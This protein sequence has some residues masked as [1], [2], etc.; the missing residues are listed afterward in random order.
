MDFEA[1][2][3]RPGDHKCS[4]ISICID[5][6]DLD[7]EFWPETYSMISQRMVKMPPR[8]EQTDQR[9]DLWQRWLI[10]H[11]VLSKVSFLLACPHVQMGWSENKIYMNIPN[12]LLYMSCY[13]HGEMTTIKFWGDPIYIILYLYFYQ[14]PTGSTHLCI[15]ILCRNLF[16]LICL[17]PGYWAVVARCESAHW[18]VLRRLTLKI[19]FFSCTWSISVYHHNE[20]LIWRIS[21]S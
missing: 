8:L 19:M 13:F 21:I 9:R 5:H 1:K 15:L 12:R 6:L 11:T 16:S 18:N 2:N 20:L 7:T 10:L 4:F 14:M 3:G 17:V